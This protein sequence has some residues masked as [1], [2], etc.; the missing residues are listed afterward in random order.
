MPNA[1]RGSSEK[2]YEGLRD[3]VVSGF[4]APGQAIAEL[5][6][7][8]RYQVSRTPVREAIRLL[9]AEGLLTLVPRR[10]V[11]V[12]EITARD[13]TE[14]SELREALESWAIEAGAGRIDRE[15]LQRLADQYDEAQDSSLGPEV[16]HYNADTELH[17]LIIEAAGNRRVVDVLRTQTLQTARL[18]ALLWRRADTQVDAHIAERL[19]DAAREH[20]E[21]IAALLDGDTD[22][23]RALLV[24]HLRKGR[25][26]L[27]HLL[28]TIDFA[29]E[30]HVSAETRT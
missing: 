11:F 21:L 1:Y 26:D 2:A 25:D 3:D 15:E 14:V 19:Q 28:A 13:V 24:E 30:P 6:A 10:G 8:E 16:F 4:Y 9:V 18:R 5:E 29:A 23:A 17:Q 12:R 22:A 7:A 20:R 27:I